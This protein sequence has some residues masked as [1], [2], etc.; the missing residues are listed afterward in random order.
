M[1]VKEAAFCTHAHRMNP[2]ADP[3]QGFLGIDFFFRCVVVFIGFLAQC[4][5]VLHARIVFRPHAHIIRIVIDAKIPVK[6]REQNLNRID[7]LIAEILIAAE[8]VL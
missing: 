5:K 1:T 2:K 3:L 6:L 4:V 8:K 7:L